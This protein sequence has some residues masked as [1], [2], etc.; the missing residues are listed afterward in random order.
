MMGLDDKEDIIFKLNIAMDF[1]EVYKD[2]DLSLTKLAA[3]VGVH[4]GDLSKIIK[5]S[6]GMGFKSYLNEIRIKKLVI[7]IQ[8]GIVGPNVT[9]CMEISGYKSRV[10]FFN[11]FK[12]R[13]GLSLTEYY[14]HLVQFNNSNMIIFESA[15]LTEF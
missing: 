15:V 14:K 10:T 12:S 3:I 8:N 13:T 4:Y 7:M 9:K 6:Y 2:A 11:A 5:A 1:Q